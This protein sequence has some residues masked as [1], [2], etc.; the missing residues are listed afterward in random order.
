VRQGGGQLP[1]QEAQAL[2]EAPRPVEAPGPVHRIH[3]AAQAEAEGGGEETPGEKRDRGRDTVRHEVRCTVGL[4][5]GL[6][7]RQHCDSEKA[8][9]TV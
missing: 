3:P 4:F 5:S 7:R 1:Y 8:G 9:V 2:P 6:D